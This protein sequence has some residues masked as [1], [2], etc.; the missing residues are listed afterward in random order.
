MATKPKRARTAKGHYK[1]DDPTTPDVNEAFE[2][3]KKPVAKPKAPALTP[4]YIWYESREKEP[5]MFDV[6]DIGALRNFS[7]GR[8]EWKVKPD[9]TE[10]FESHHFYKTGRVV[11]KVG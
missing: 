10:R 7:N 4:D 1:A 5:S 2:Q 8:L 11:K 9:D 3:E 6:A